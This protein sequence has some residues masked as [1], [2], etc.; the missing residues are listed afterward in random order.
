MIDQR[1][2]TFLHSSGKE[3]AFAEYRIVRPD[4]TV[5]WIWDRAF[6]IRDE[7][8][9]VI[10]VVG[11]AEDVTSRKRA[12]ED[13]RRALQTEKELGELKS[14]FISMTSHEFRTPLS[15]ILSAAE[16]LENYGHKWPDDKK[17]RYLRQIQTNVINM[18][19][20]LEEVLIISKGEA[21]KIEFQPAPQ[22]IDLVCRELAE[23]VQLSHPTHSIRYSADV[24]DHPLLLDEQLLRRILI[25][26]LSNAVKYSPNSDVVD[27][28]VEQHDAELVFSITDY[29]LGI[30]PEARERLFETFYRA[31]N[32]AGIQGTG[33]GL[34]IVKKAVELH[35]GTIE[36][37]SEVNR[38][39]TFIVTLPVHSHPA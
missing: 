5:G 2:G 33:L 7:H 32:V 8:G 17:L 31:G 26:L 12:E 39:T 34:A 9:Q 6:P 20:L 15:G 27:F 30:P 23:Q 36:Y 38:G 21:N 35:G 4:N 25:N 18:N 3:T 37:T 22:N 11:V 10:R 16:L 24:P 1:T 28:D 19:Q 13:L 14:R 29:G